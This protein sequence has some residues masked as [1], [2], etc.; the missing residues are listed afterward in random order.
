MRKTL[1]AFVCLA[2]TQS[3]GQA[4]LVV[5]NNAWLRIDN[6]AC[7]V[8]ENG[9]ANALTVAGTGANVRSEGEANR[10]RW[11]I[12]SNTGTYVLPWT[13][14]AGTKIPLTYQVTAAGSAAGSIVF[15]TYAGPTWD[16]NTYRPTDVTHMNNYFTG[17]ANSSQVVDRFWIMDPSAAG[18]AYATKPGVSITFVYPQ[19]EVLVGN[20]IT[21]TTP[22]GAQRFNNSAGNI[23]GDLLPIGVFAANVPAAGLN[24]VSAAAVNGANNFRSW[25]LSN[26]SQPL[27]IEL[28]SF[29]ARCEQ[30]QVIVEWTTATER[31]NDYFAV[32]KSRDGNDWQVIGIVD[33]AGNSLEAIN[34]MLVDPEPTSQ[35]MYR[36]SQTDF[37]GT[38]TTSD[39]VVG[40]CE[41]TGGI[42]IVTAW[43]DGH[44]VNVIVSSSNEGLHDV[45]LLDTQGKVLIQQNS[46]SIYNGITHLRLPKNT[47]ASGVYVVRLQNGQ[48]MLSRKVL[49]Y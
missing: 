45:Y 28:I 44:D 49:L 37:D 10:I 22:L 12:G 25:T 16:N 31:N 48:D 38:T 19:T 23:W 33:G 11:Q 13:N 42:E 32:E 29:R 3:F 9:A 43:D 4:R 5:N 1:L 2:T 30:S 14:P 46:V 35:A 36:L 41:V 6:G 26:P 17:A 18:F 34:Y 21:G 40:G 20:T 24:T 8:L 15:S 27:P 7:V 47:I 39:V